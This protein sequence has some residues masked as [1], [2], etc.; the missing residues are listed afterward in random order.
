MQPRSLA[1]AQLTTR[2]G[3]E[4]GLAIVILIC[5][6]KSWCIK[7]L[8][9]NIEARRFE[10]YLQSFVRLCRSGPLFTNLKTSK[11]QRKSSS[12]NIGGLG[13]L[14]I[15]QIF[16]GPPD[17]EDLSAKTYPCHIGSIPHIPW[18][19]WASSGPWHA[20]APSASGGWRKPRARR[21]GAR[22]E[23]RH[24][25]A[26]RGGHL[27]CRQIVRRGTTQRSW[28]LRCRPS[29]SDR[30]P[31]RSADQRQNLGGR[32]RAA[33]KEPARD[34]G[35]LAADG[36]ASPPRAEERTGL[37]TPAGSQR[38]SATAAGRRGSGCRC[39]C[40]LRG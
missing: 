10:D 16:K 30:A 23:A 11:R 27:R 13:P 3:I 34:G 22:G 31:S 36:G 29:V 8:F 14:K 6:P 19:S 28:L 26:R 2:V 7:H 40:R 33:P 9:T 5:D 1:R 24:S 4:L 20:S 17:L 25:A 35:L 39:R 38:T 21:A 15:C 18:A 12:F 32:W 37:P